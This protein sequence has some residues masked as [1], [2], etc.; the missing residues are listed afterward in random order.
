[1]AEL[2]DAHIRGVRFSPRLKHSSYG[3]AD[4]HCRFDPGSLHCVYS[5]TVRAP[6]C[7]S[8]GGGSIPP[9]HQ[10]FLIVCGWWGVVKRSIGKCLFAM[11]AHVICNHVSAVRFRQEAH[12]NFNQYGITEFT[13]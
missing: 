13:D 1:M 8:G 2:V 9:K 4:V 12:I 3:Y 7:G 6:D 11:A 5:S 10:L